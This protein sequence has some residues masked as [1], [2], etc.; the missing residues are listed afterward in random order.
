MEMRPD[1]KRKRATKLAISL[2]EAKAMHAE[3]AELERRA[4]SVGHTIAVLQAEQFTLMIEA[5]MLRRK[6]RETNP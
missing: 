5:A 3:A 1:I 4:A 2:R 6:A